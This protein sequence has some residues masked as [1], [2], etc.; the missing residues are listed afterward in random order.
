ML[1]PDQ[2]IG[3]PLLEFILTQ[4]PQPKPFTNHSAESGSNLVKDIWADSEVVPREALGE[5]R[6]R[7]SFQA[8]T[9]INIRRGKGCSGLWVGDGQKQVDIASFTN[10]TSEMD[11]FIE[12]FQ[13]LMN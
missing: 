6:H 13:N 5:G 7:H 1:R 11:L 9:Q 8:F 3:L 2:K 4:N 12:G 10:F